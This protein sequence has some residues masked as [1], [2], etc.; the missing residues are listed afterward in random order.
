MSLSNLVLVFSLVLVFH[1]KLKTVSGSPQWV[2]NPQA[3]TGPIG[4]GENTRNV[5][6]AGQNDNSGNTFLY[7]A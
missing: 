2:W 5:V 1:S 7:K 4:G 6:F 3:N